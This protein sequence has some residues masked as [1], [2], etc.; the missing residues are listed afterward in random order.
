MWLFQYYFIYK[1]WNLNFM[2]PEMSLLFWINLN[3]LKTFL[4]HRLYENRQR[5]RSD[6]WIRVCQS[7]FKLKA[8]YHCHFCLC[9]WRRRRKGRRRRRERRKR[10]KD[11]TAWF[12]KVCFLWSK[13]A[14]FLSLESHLDFLM[15]P[16]L[17]WQHKRRSSSFSPKVRF[18]INNFLGLLVIRISTALSS[19]P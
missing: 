8:S 9:S 14:N 12:T 5:V 18:R 15:T 10:R 4:A 16:V 13:L 6:S 3:H 17:Y 7:L 2:C 11:F 1:Y 19:L